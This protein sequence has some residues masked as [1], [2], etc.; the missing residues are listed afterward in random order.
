LY[1]AAFAFLYR[2]FAFQPN[3]LSCVSSSV[4]GNICG[5]TA[6]TYRVQF[7]GAKPL[8]TFLLNTRLDE[9]FAFGADESGLVGFFTIVFGHLVPGL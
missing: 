8:L 1:Q 9:I 4:Y 5:I 6:A 3:G 2:S 7:H